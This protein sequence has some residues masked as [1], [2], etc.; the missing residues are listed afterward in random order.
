MRIIQPE[1]AKAL[2]EILLTHEAR[3]LSPGSPDPDKVNIML[4]H[5]R[6]MLQDIGDGEPQASDNSIKAVGQLIYDEDQKM[7]AMRETDPGKV[8]E[9][10]CFILGLTKALS[11]FKKNIS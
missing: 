4:D 8:Q 10:F 7:E 1:E 6:G 2:R 5:L 9:K 11:M 3:T